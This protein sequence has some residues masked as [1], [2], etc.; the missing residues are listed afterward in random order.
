M[1]RMLW[2][3]SALCC[4]YAPLHYFLRNPPARNEDVGLIMSAQCPTDYSTASAGKASDSDV[5]AQDAA[6]LNGRQW[7]GIGEARRDVAA[8]GSSITMQLQQQAAASNNPF[9]PTALTPQIIL[10]HQTTEYLHSEYY[11]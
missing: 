4:L 2:C 10:A 7:I 8:D 9:M 1:F 11:P 5:C 6:A 3:I